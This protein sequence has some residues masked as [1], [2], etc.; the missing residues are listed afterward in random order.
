MV[1]G[2]QFI[3]EENYVNQTPF[4]SVRT[5]TDTFDHKG[6]AAF[7]QNCEKAAQLSADIVCAMLKA[8][9]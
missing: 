4:V 7:G 8:L 1:T 5:I 3:E 6:L 2:E 9:P